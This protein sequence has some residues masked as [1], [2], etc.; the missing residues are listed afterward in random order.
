MN[1]KPPIVEQGPSEEQDE[2]APDRASTR[3]L[4][5]DKVTG[6]LTEP[7][8]N[9]HI[10]TSG[11]VDSEPAAGAGPSLNYPVVAFGSSAG[12]LQPMKDILGILPT[13][14]GMAFVLVP[15]LAPDQVSHLKEITEQYTRMPVHAIRD[16]EQP[17][18]D[19]LYVLQPNEV[20]QI[21]GGRFVVAE[22]GAHER[23]PHTIDTFFRSLGQD[24]QG[25]A[26]GVVLSGADADGALGLKSIRG[27]G[28]F[29]I[30]QT[31]ETAQHSSMPRSS[32]SAD[33]ADMVVSPREIGVE[34]A[35]LAKQFF[36]P[37][38]ISLEENQPTSDQE[39]FHRILLLLRTHSGLE[40]RQ[41]KQDTIRRRVARRMVLL[42]M[43]SLADYARYLQVRHDELTNLQEDVLIGVTR[44]F[45]D[46]SV[47]HALNAVVLPAF[48]EN[49][50]PQRP[51]RLWCAGC[52]T[53]EEVYSLAITF[54][55]YMAANGMDNP[56]QIFGTDASERS[57]ETARQ[58][59]YPDSLVGEISPE[60]IRR[61][62]VKVDRGYQ[63]SKRVRD[64]CIFAR[65]NLCSDPPFSRIDFLTCR[66]VL[67]YF[68]QSLQR[69]VMQTFH[70]ALEASGYL[71]LGTSETLREYD[72]WFTPVDRKN[73][74][75]SKLGSS[76]PGGYNLPMHRQVRSAQ[77]QSMQSG[78]PD[79][80]WSELEMQRAGDR[81]V[82]AR[83]A[84]PGLIVDE[85]LNVLQVRG[86]TSAYVEL[87]SGTVSLNLLRVV[88]EGMAPAMRKAA[89]HAIAENIPVT[90]LVAVPSGDGTQKQV[91]IDVLPLSLRASNN[92]CYM[93]LFREVEERSGLQ[94]FE[95]PP[96]PNLSTDEKEQLVLQLRQDLSSTRF[97]LQSLIEE[98]DARNQELVSANEEIQSANEELQSTNEE[99]ETTKEELQ[100][101]NEELQTVNDELQ[102]RNTVLVQTGNDL[103]NLLTSVNIPLLML[104]DNLEIRQFTPPMERLLNMRSADIGRKISEIRL[105]LSVEDV[106][107][108]LQDVLESLGTREV[109]VQDRHGKWHLMRVRPYRTSENKIEGLVLVLVDIDQLRHSQQG[110]R[111][112]RDFADCIVAS[113]PMPIIVL[114]TDCTIRT[115]NKSF[116]DLTELGDRELT[117]R[118]LPD[119]VKLKWG[120]DGFREKL[121]T[122][123]AAQPGT[124]LEFE[125]HSTIGQTRVLFVKGQALLSDGSRIVLLTMEDITLRRHAEHELAAQRQALE[126]N[127]EHTS[128]TLLRA[129]KELR[130]LATHLFSVQ[131]EERQRVARELH[132]DIAQR[133]TALSLSLRQARSGEGS[134]EKNGKQNIAMDAVF[135]QIE[136]LSRD[137][138]HLSHHLHPAILDDLGVVAALNALVNE[139]REREGMLATYVGKDVPELIPRTASTAIY[140]VVQESLRNVAKHAGKTHVKVL[141]ERRDGHLRLDIRDFG[142]GF[143][144]EDPGSDSGLGIISMKERARI[145]GGTFAIRSE[146]GQGTSITMEVPFAEP[147]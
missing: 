116:R 86:Q 62:F 103:N 1:E 45:R 12:G 43:E 30:V 115:V 145:A 51:V 11:S 141:L 121:G 61:F 28:G 23:T 99:L 126:Q 5:A 4:I 133:L 95:P 104:T 44:F 36:R 14:T 119:L 69:Q 85:R 112:A 47:W 55:E 40:L 96:S 2:S 108:I 49:G 147:D 123:V 41:Y 110:M 8:P 21:H 125:H 81:V 18:P 144:Q 42:R 109:E 67:I 20:A 77:V 105:Q 19:N 90:R 128:E 83:L 107:P 82:L 146:L 72:E 53:G 89:E 117:G 29:A 35:R 64:L 137:V 6:E 32:I 138:R 136:T 39:S 33:H 132:D 142:I 65:Q 134:G 92:R 122:L 71:L 58:A 50:P 93:V 46:P 22:R 54:L 97:H 26:V 38:V 118:S 101:A 120:L 75:Y 100:S 48:F 130:D 114:E 129:Q 17:Q 52:S 10:E 31:P 88:R 3:D 78:H 70:Y 106:E 60:R 91:Q 84:P 25:N 74:I 98:R 102:Q 27:D 66:N 7:A 79:Q 94:M 34:L 24:L 13:N 140:R 15:H 56:L 57:I 127:I 87:A 76:M 68:N 9:G 63:L 37:E 59:I 124:V 80:L 143:D 139:F 111:E 135:A 131:E 16:G 113:M 73:K